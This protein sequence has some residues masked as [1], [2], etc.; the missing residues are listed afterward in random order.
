MDNK[1]NILQ[2]ENTEDSFEA[3]I[4]ELGGKIIEINPDK[5]SYI[6]PLE[7]GEI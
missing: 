4:K 2:D 1:S 5:T 6:N 7:I 3:L